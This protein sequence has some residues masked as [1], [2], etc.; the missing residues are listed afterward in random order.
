MKKILFG[1]FIIAVAYDANAQQ[2]LLTKP[3]DSSLLRLL[4]PSCKLKPADSSLNSKFF[5][6]PPI[7][8]KTQPNTSLLFAN[9]ETFYSTMPVIKVDGGRM[10]V[11]KPG[12]N[13]HY[14]MLVKKY[15]VVNP[16]LKVQPT[17]P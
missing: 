8:L 15:K 9:S 17:I 16:L 5:K 11:V 14:T 13:E 10:P 6:L 1:L 7:D 2:Q 12:S 4:N 3:T